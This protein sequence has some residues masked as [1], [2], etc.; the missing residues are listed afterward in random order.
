[1]LLRRLFEII[2]FVWHGSIMYV[3]VVNIL[4]NDFIHRSIL[5]WF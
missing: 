2:I 5:L 1:M 4:L 3:K